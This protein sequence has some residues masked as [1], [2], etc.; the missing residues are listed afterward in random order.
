MVLC[1]RFTLTVNM[2]ELAEQFGCPVIVPDYRPRYNA[3]PTQ[4]MPAVIKD[5]G[6]N[7]IVPLRW[8][9]IPHWAKDDTLGRKLINARR[10][11]LA[12]KPAFRGSLLTRRCLIPADGYFEWLKGAGK[13]QP[14]RIT[15]KSRR[16]FAFAGLWDEWQNSAGKTVQS[17][18]II[19]AEPA[20]AVRHIHARMPLI[21]QKQDESRWLNERFTPAQAQSWLNTFSAEENLTAYPV[22]PLVNSP[23]ND[24]PMLIEPVEL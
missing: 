4:F 23:A 7:R 2:D 14:L 17:F 8:G 10:E 16:L 12:E 1:G 9:L 6:Q 3:A 18:T 24:H 22:S 15:V 5:A 20:P 11:T 21:L 13:K 19:T